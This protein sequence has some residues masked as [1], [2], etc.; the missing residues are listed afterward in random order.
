M[1]RYRL[2]LATLIA[3]LS[4]VPAQ[5]DRIKE[6]GGFQGIRA[7][8]LT[9]DGIVVG[10]AGTGDDNLEYTIQSVKA[11]ASRLGLQLPAGINPGLKHAAVVMITAD[12]TPF[13]KPGQ[14]I[15]I[16]VAS[17]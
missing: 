2:I 17:M 13:A 15:D 7:N 8:Q 3:C 9:G 5:A 14:R 11:V 1:F 12:M 6:L 16:T 10:L 4:A